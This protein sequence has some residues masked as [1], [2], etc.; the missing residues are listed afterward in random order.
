MGFLDNAINKTKEA[1]DVA[2]KKAEEMIGEE[3][4]K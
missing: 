1:V 3:K 4:S 2:C